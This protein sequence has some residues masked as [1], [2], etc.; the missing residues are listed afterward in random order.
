[1]DTK[2]L[3]NCFSFLIHLVQSTHSKVLNEYVCYCE[4]CLIAGGILEWSRMTCLGETLRWLNSVFKYERTW[5]GGV[6]GQEREDRRKSSQGLSKT[7]QFMPPFRVLHDLILQALPCLACYHQRQPSVVLAFPPLS[8]SLEYLPL[9]IGQTESTFHFMSGWKYSL[10][11]PYMTYLS[12]L[13]SSLNGSVCRSDISG[14]NL[15]R[16]WE[17]IVVFNLR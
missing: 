5:N 15:Q 12:L 10:R 13:L 9:L 4:V 3:E 17:T 8:L 2:A 16:T 14:L 1:M 11:K 6:R 7:K